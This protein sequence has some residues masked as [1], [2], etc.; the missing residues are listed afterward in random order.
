[1]GRKKYALDGIPAD[2]V[3]TVD[4]PKTF[5]GWLMEGCGYVDVLGL[6]RRETTAR[7]ENI[8]QPLQHL[9]FF[10]GMH[11]YIRK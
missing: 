5:R 10:S 1:M 6:E 3:V 2:A 9:F 4:E 8:N 7:N 11:I